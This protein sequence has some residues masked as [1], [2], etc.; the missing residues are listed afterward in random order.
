MQHRQ[1]RFRLRTLLSVVAITAL[2]IAWGVK[3]RRVGAIYE[4]TSMPGAPSVEIPIHQ[5]GWLVQ[6]I[7]SLASPSKPNPNTFTPTTK[8]TER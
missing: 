8:R 4:A 5:K 6:L 7:E 1:L 2:F 3:P